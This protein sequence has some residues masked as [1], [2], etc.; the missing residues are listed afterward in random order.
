MREELRTH[1]LREMLLEDEDYKK[2]LSSIKK[3][4]MNPT[5]DQKDLLVN[6]LRDKI[7]ARAKE[8][9]T[10]PQIEKFIDGISEI[11]DIED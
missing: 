10:T 6:T 8:L 3:F 11:G 5:A 9:L 2:T 4:Q 7:T 1:I